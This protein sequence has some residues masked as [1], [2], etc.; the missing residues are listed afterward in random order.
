MT[1]YLIIYKISISLH[2]KSQKQ[3]NVH[4][5]DVNALFLYHLLVLFTVM[6][7]FTFA[8]LEQVLTINLFDTWNFKPQ[9]FHGKIPL[10]RTFRFP[11]QGL[12]P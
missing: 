9:T 4:A 6:R 3:F 7:A 1:R 10:L 12:L 8:S 5:L 11:V 2:S